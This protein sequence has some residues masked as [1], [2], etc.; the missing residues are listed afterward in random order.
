MNESWEH[1][2]QPQNETLWTSMW[3]GHSILFHRLLPIPVLATE[4]K[5]KDAIFLFMT[6]FKHS[7]ARLPA[8]LNLLTFTITRKNK[9]KSFAKMQKCH[10]WILNGT[11]LLQDEKGTI[12]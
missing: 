2:I 12:E 5:G 11:Y 7:F 9:S 6:S 10:T 8:S 1:R 4:K 3:I